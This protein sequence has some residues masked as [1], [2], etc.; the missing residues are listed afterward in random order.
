VTDNTA[1]L[2]QEQ[3]EVPAVAVGSRLSVFRQ[4]LFQQ[5]SLSLEERPVFFEHLLFQLQRCLYHD[6][7]KHDRQTHT[8]G[9]TDRVVLE[10]NHTPCVPSCISSSHWWDT[11]SRYSHIL[12]TTTVTETKSVI[13][14]VSNAVCC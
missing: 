13:S 1:N 2:E 4:S 14:K 5:S 6:H 9:W 12:A 10:H 11:G 7:I 3:H 8:D